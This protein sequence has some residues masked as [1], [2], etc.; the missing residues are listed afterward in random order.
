MPT[1]RGIS[2]WKPGAFAAINAAWFLL[3]IWFLLAR[4]FAWLGINTLPDPIGGLVPLAV[5]WAGAFGGIAISTVGICRHAAHWDHR[6]NYWHLFRPALGAT[7]GVV[8][9]LIVILLVGSVSLTTSAGSAA[10]AGTDFAALSPASVGTLAVIA[11]VL[12]YRE[13]T[14]RELIKRVADTLFTPEG[15]KQADLSGGSAASTPSLDFGR[16]PLGQASTRTVRISN[17]GSAEALI[18]G[19]QISPEAG[20]AALGIDDTGAAGAPVPAGGSRELGVR[21]TPDE[22]RTYKAE[23]S[24][25][26]GDDTVVVALA[27]AGRTET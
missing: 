13:S 9:V 22:A 24:L 4:H 15:G 2:G 14:I 16:V 11:F 8:G 25:L 26:V 7:F 23:M 12:G 19:V 5:P 3:F 1:P 6:W 20:F 18:V 27:G 10:E 17:D 21:F